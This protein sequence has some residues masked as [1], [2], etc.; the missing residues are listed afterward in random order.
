MKEWFA[1]WGKSLISVEPS[2]ARRVRMTRE[3]ARKLHAAAWRR[4][5][6]AALRAAVVEALAHV[7]VDEQ[8]GVRAACEGVLAWL[9]A[10]RSAD[11][12]EAV[13]VAAR[14]AFDAAWAA[15]G[16]QAPS[17]AAAAAAAAS[18]P[19]VVAWTATWHAICAA[20]Q[21]AEAEAARTATAWAASETAAEVEAAVAN[22]IAARTFAAIDAECVRATPRRISH[23]VCNDGFWVS[24]QAG[25]N[26]YSSPDENCGPWTEFELGYP[27][28]EEPRLLKY[29]QV[30]S[31]D[32]LKS[33][34]PYVP[35]EV[36]REVIAAHG[37]TDVDWEH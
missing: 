16:Q 27:S 37:G 14:A 6:T 25:I 11:G 31:K 19:A 8:W 4:C 36:V 3:S 26:M 12:R 1:Q 13:N 32:P 33:V 10:G 20:S 18:E 30:E 34:Y 28:A 17:S 2:A 15:V 5:E 7:P 23:V 24:V 9:N 29:L 35:I 22:H 21:A